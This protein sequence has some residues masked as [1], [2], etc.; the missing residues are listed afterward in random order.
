[1]SQIIGSIE[2]FAFERNIEG[3]MP[4]D[5]RT[6]KVMEHQ[7][8]YSLL[9]VTYGGDGRTFFALPNYKAPQK[10]MRYCIAVEGEYPPIS[11]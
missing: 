9:G 5:G 3:W 8:L 11:S 2:L 7:P 6:L 1:M 4:C 10:G